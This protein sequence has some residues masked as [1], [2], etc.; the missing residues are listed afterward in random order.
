[1]PAAGKHCRQ[2]L[3]RELSEHPKANLVL[4]GDTAVQ[5]VL[6]KKGIMK[7]RGCV[8]ELGTRRV[9]STI[10]PAALMRDPKMWN[11]VVS[12]LMYART[13]Y[14]HKLP[15]QR[16]VIEPTI[17]QVEEWWAEHVKPG[18]TYFVDIETAGQALRCIG[19]SSNES[20]ALCVPFWKSDGSFYWNHDFA[21]MVTELFNTFFADDRYKK[22]FQNGVFDTN[23]LEG[24]GFEVNGWI[25]DTMLM[26]HL[27][28]SEL[29]HSLAFLHSIYVRG[30]YY[31][32]MYH[33][34]KDEEEEA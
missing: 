1:M 20:D 27:V 7:H 6:G 24:F 22:V 21:M 29:K 9:M 3:D 18:G 2:Y 10:H 31:K 4:L 28:Y 15:D 26:H 25:A 19:L 5:V 32:D 12:D 23:V 11:V 8:Y 33:A 30:A 16:F 13:M 34:A 17:T 14:N